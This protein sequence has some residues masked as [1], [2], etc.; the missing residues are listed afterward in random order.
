MRDVAAATV[1]EETTGETLHAEAVTMEQEEHTRE[2]TDQLNSTV[3]IVNVQD[4]MLA[5]ALSRPE[6][7]A[8]E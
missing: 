1:E 3:T 6:T 2:R 7:S 5:N 8:W 4:T